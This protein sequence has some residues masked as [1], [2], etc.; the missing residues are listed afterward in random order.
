M[1]Y[2]SETTKDG[3]QTK[4]GLNLSE[5]AQYS[6]WT[7][8]G[9]CLFVFNRCQRVCVPAEELLS[10]Y[11]AIYHPQVSWKINPVPCQ[12][13]PSAGADLLKGKTKILVGN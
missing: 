2:N 6:V 10:V 11:L 3:G 8:A 13:F 7:G 1:L 4:V 9:V 5:R 12:T